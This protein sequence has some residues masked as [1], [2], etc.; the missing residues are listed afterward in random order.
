MLKLPTDPSKLRQLSSTYGSVRSRLLRL[1]DDG[2]SESQRVEL[3]AATF[4]LAE[5]KI[6]QNDEHIAAQLYESALELGLQ[7]ISP[8]YPLIE[9]QMYRLP[10]KF[11]NENPLA[12]LLHKLSP[13]DKIRLFGNLSNKQKTAVAK[14]LT[15]RDRKLLNLDEEAK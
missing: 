8:R 5:V 4:D 10:F 11:N 6:A 9:Q 13:A 7:F 3:L 2:L 12:E 14:A 1:V 15:P